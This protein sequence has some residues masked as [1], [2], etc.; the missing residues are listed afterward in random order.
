VRRI[1]RADR[2]T[3][4]Q[5]IFWALLALS[6]LFAAF[7]VGL[8]AAPAVGADVFGF[9]AQGAAAQLYV[10]AIAFRD[11]ALAAYLAGQTLFASRRAV[12]IV[13]LATLVIP[14][15]DMLLLLATPGAD[16]S[17]IALH[18]ASAAC[19]ASIALSLRRTP[20]VPHREP[21]GNI[22]RGR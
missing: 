2:L 10:R 7:G 16:R 15:G 1:P 19:F 12:M 20:C 14:I 13:A 22:W 4:R 18:L 9:P 6:L 21:A 11:I 5:P 8:L 17:R 3:R